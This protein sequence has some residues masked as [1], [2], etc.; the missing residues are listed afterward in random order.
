M[1]YHEFRAMNTAIL[2]AAEGETRRVESGFR[3]AE[4]LVHALEQRFTRFTETSELADLNRSA[5]A[6]F[7]ASPEMYEV[8]ALATDYYETTGGLFNPGI[9][10][11]LER[12]GYDRS[13]DE[14]RALGDQPSV[15]DRWP[16]PVPD[17]RFVELDPARRAIRLPVGLRIDLGGIGKGWIA[18]Q[19][20]RLLNR[21]S[22]ACVVDAGGDLFACG[23]PTGD[24]AWMV[25]LE[26][27]FDTSRD[28]TVLA[29]PPGGVATSTI[30]RRR[31]KQDGQER[32]HLIDPRTGQPA[33]TPW[34]SVTV[35]A[36]HAH[37]AEALAKA[38]LIGGPQTAGRI[39]SRYPRAAYL[40]VDENG[41]L[42][43]SE[44]SQKVIYG[45]VQQA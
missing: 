6:W 29:V 7:L 15:V 16:R 40:A 17:F 42:W 31:W 43:G 22:S 2:M 34:V 44:N 19:A 35:V 23:I 32:H 24:Q 3:Q 36:A 33:V 41:K 21:F 37:L 4:A 28:V 14:V 45:N 30:M 8:V 27:P 18:E 9:L 38:L 11:A 26:D 39:L 13:I 1:K 20:S 5:G 12:A 10:S 25:S